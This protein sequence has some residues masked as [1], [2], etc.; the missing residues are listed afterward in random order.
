MVY[1][2]NVKHQKTLSLP[3]RT[4][5]MTVLNFL[6]LLKAYPKVASKKLNC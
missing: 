3:K 4:S 1:L 2:E 5:D 6:K